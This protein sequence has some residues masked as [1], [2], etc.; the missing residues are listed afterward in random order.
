MNDWIEKNRQQVIQDGWYKTSG[1]YWTKYSPMTEVEKKKQEEQ[2]EL[3][4]KHERRLTIGVIGVILLIIAIVY[5]LWKRVGKP[6]WHIAKDNKE[7]IVT[8]ESMKI[9]SIAPHV[10]PED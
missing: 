1:D 5:L 9:Y 7:E 8:L 3:Q 6:S 2:F 4:R 10:G